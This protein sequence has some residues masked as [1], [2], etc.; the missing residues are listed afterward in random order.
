[1]DNPL[2]GEATVVCLVF[3]VLIAGV[4]VISIHRRRRHDRRLQRWAD[5]NGWALTRHPRVEWGRQLPGANPHGI[6]HTFSTMLHGH[7]VNV[8]QYSVTD[9]SDATTT[10]THHHVVTV[11]TLDQPYPSTQIEPRSRASRLKNKL[12]SPDETATGNPD[13]DRDFRIRTTA[14]AALQQWFTQ[15]LITAHLTG[16]VPPA[17]SV[18]GTEL[19]HHQ[20][21]RLHPDEIPAHAA[22]VL[23]L[24]DLLDNHLGR[25]P[26]RAR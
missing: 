1:M 3:A 20:P 7:R 5:T 10:N 17:W 12:L 24:A 9:A 21:G 11:V 26:A 15:P 8:A 4:A 6:S 13:F 25:D 23:P 2:A 14:P 19:L 16:Q 22:A 18:H